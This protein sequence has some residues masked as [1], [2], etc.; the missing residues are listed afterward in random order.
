MV[1]DPEGAAYIARL[2]AAGKADRSQMRLSDGDRLHAFQ[3]IEEAA[4]LRGRPALFVHCERDYFIPAW[5][6]K[7]LAEEAGAPWRFL[8][9][10][11]YEIYE[12]RPQEELIAIA[13]EFYWAAGPS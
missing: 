11:H 7:T 12:G 13:I 10:G 1:R 3:P 6:S 8:P 4:R 5:H 9:Y 2:A